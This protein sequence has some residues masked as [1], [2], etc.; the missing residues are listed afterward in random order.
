MNLNNFYLFFPG[1]Y[2]RTRRSRDAKAITIALDSVIDEIGF[3][4]VEFE[5]RKSEVISTANEWLE[6]WKRYSLIS[7]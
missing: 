6:F 7:F 3:D 5:R 4:S 1:Q 2:Y